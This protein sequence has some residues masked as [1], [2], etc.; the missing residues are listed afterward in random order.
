M[1]NNYHVISTIVEDKPPQIFGVDDITIK[2]GETFDYSEGVY[3]K[4]DN[5]IQVDTSINGFVD[6]NTVGKYELE[7]IAKDSNG[8]ITKKIRKVDVKN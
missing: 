1:T 5:D 2:K 8:N 7:Y 4:D 6:T 3:V